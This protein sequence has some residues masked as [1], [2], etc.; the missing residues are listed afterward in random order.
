M[1]DLD[2]RIAERASE[3][4]YHKGLHAM[5]ALIYTSALS[6]E[7]MLVTGD[8]DFER[9]EDVLILGRKDLL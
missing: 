2:E 9:L 3:V 4:S 6:L 7:S 5:G 1:I 8:S